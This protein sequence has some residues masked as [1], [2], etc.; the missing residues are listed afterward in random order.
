MKKKVVSKQSS[1]WFL[2]V[3]AML[4]MVKSPVALIPLMKTLSR[5]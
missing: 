2:Y 5:K 3:G 1:K 4:V